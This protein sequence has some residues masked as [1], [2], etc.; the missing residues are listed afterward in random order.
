MKTILS[1]ILIIILS[2]PAFSDTENIEQQLKNA[3]QLYAQNKFEDAVKQYEQIISENYKSPELF[4]NTANAYYR[5]NE[6]GKAIYYYEKAKMLNPNDDDINYNLELAKLRVKNLPPEVPVIFPVRIFR[7]IS[8]KVSAELW[9]YLSILFF[10]VFLTVLF[11]YYTAKNSK[12]K[13]IKLLTAIVILFFSILTFVFMQYQV[14]S[15]NAHNQAIVIS[16][17]VKAKSSPDVSANDLFKIYE[18]Y[19][20]KI[21]NE[22]GDWCE[23]KLTDGKK[24]WLKKEN[25]MIL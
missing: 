13:K 8:L 23:I 6:T 5:L 9:A 11:L 15:L 17:E 3:N 19:K 21:E 24:A 22:K 12:S 7:Q 2:F 1:L 4:F 10:V 25:L 20:V 16:K 18:G 14:F